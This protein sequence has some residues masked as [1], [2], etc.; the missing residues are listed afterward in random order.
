MKWG[1]DLRQVESAVHCYFSKYGPA[2]LD[3]ESRRD[4]LKMKN[5]R[6]FLLYTMELE[7][8]GVG[9]KDIRIFISPQEHKVVSHAYL[10]TNHNH[11]NALTCSLCLP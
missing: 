7:S 3:S 2:S 8:L 9:L 1:S 6:F 4:L 10:G 11:Q 5:P